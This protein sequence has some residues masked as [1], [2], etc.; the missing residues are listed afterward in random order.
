[1][2]RLLFAMAMVAVAVAAPPAGAGTIERAYA[3][4][5]AFLKAEAAALQGQ[6]E[7]F[8]QGPSEEER[9]IEQELAALESQLLERRRHADA[10]EDRVRKLERESGGEERGQRVQEVLARAA[11]SLATHGFT[12]GPAADAAAPGGPAALEGAVRATLSRAIEALEAGALIRREEG[13]FFLVDGTQVSGVLVRWGRVAAFGVS[14]RGAGA[15]VPAGAGRFRLWPEPAAD[16]AVALARGAPPDTPPDTLR[17]FLFEAADR[18]IQERKELTVAGE[19]AAGGSIAVIIAALGVL[20]LLMICARAAFLLAE[21][22]RAQRVLGEVLPLCAAGRFHEAGLCVRDAAGAMARVLEAA[23]HDRTLERSQREDRV[24]ESMLAAVP[25]VE[26]F[27]SSIMVFAAVAPLLGLLGT[28]TGMIAT[29]DVITEFGTGDPRMLS[30]GI[31]EA[32]ITTK[33]GLVVAIPC[34]LAGTLLNGSADAFLTRLQ[35]G[36]L[37]VMNVLPGPEARRAG[38]GARA[39]GPV[40]VGAVGAAAAAAVGPLPRTHEPSRAVAVSAGEG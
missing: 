5:L 18:P 6:L 21:T 27:G 2:T 31:S 11:E 19:L 26:R 35:Y 34:L 4:E 20:A 7:G 36:A 12:M 23:L 24:Q 17:L 13:S 40:A 32:L 9:R 29:F 1:M 8:E 39:V 22:R 37:R 33:L 25:A 38:E 16:E 30:G 3:R 10:L 28:V 14:D 15:L